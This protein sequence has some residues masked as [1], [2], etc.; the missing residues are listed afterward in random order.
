VKNGSSSSRD[1]QK[2]LKLSKVAVIGGSTGYGTA[3][4]ADSVANFKQSGMEV[5]YQ[6]QIDATQPD[7]LRMRVAGA[8]A[9]VPWTVSTGMIARLLNARGSIKS[10]SFDASW[11]SAAAYPGFRRWR[12]GKISLWW[13]V[14]AVAELRRQ[15]GYG[16][17]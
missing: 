11:Q 6:A 12:K 14:S 16:A 5:V 4:V 13:I 8:Q 15:T 2:V 3:A 7:M 10:C 17:D 1:C 9:I